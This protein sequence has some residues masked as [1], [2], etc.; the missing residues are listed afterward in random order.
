M[1]GPERPDERPRILVVDDELHMREVLELGLMQH[2]FDVR[3]VA[4]GP[5]GLAVLLRQPGRVFTRD[6]LIDLAWGEDIAVAPNAVATYITYLRA[7]LE[8]PPLQKL[9]HTIR[10]VGYSLRS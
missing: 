10:R 1:N 2:G 9:I 3:A 5:A 8:Q 4:D 7:K 6:Q